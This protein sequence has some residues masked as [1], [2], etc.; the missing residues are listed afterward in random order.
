MTTPEWITLPA[1][2]TEAML[3]SA[4][5]LTAGIL[6][7]ER[8]RLELGDNK[9]AF[10]IKM[11]GRYRAMVAARPPAPDHIVGV[12]QMV[13]PAPD[14][15]ADVGK[16]IAPDH[17]ELI[18]GRPPDPFPIFAPLELIAAAR[19]VVA[20]W[21][22]PKWADLPPTADAIHRLRRALPDSGET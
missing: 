11:A 3:E 4:W 19:A 6:P 15:I 12:N 17:A 22:S 9:G 5:T 20:R 21:D 13:A 2:P 16:L 7:E 8:M 1:E 18:A 10:K 14:H